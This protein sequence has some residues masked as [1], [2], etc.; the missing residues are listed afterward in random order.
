MESSVPDQPMLDKLSMP[1]SL[2]PVHGEGCNSASRTEPHLPEGRPCP[3]SSGPGGGAQ[4][5]VLPG[6]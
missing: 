2:E 4:D 3:L 5:T 6:H 1:L